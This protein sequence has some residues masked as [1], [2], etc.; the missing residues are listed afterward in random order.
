MIENYGQ[1]FDGY[2][3][4]RDLTDTKLLLFD[5]SAISTMNQ[6]VYQAQL[7]MALSLIW[8]HALIMVENRMLC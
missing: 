5:S 4:M 1:L 3:T 8:S 6:N 2:S 7:Y